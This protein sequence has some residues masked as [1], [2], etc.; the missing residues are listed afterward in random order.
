MLNKMKVNKSD[1]P[2]FIIPYSFI[3][4]SWAQQ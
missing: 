2:L 1:L 3:G 4:V